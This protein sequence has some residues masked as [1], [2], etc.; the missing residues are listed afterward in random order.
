MNAFVFFFVI[1]PYLCLSVFLCGL[2]LRYVYSQNT[3]NARSS[4]IFEKQTLRVGSMLFHAGILFSFGGHIIGL[5]LPPSALQAMGLN[6]QLH[7]EL[8]GGAGKILAPLVVVGLGILLFRRLANAHVRKTTIA[9]DIIVILLILIN[10]STG[11]YQSYIAHFPVFE[12]IGPW[13]RSILTFYPAPASLVMVPL[14]MQVHIL[15]GL[16][17]IALLPFTRLVHIFS[18]PLTYLTFPPLLYRKRY[19]NT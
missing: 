12:T 9:T 10:G 4:E 3:W 17:L 5:V 1:Y 11:F 19:R 8:A 7:M 6:A 15:S 16:T 14:F 13:L 2:C 18:L